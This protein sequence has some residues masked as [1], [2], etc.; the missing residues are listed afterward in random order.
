MQ[1]TEIQI[2]MTKHVVYNFNDVIYPHCIGFHINS[3]S[4]I[5]SFYIFDNNDNQTFHL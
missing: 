3:A 2:P 5:L 4:F 1:K